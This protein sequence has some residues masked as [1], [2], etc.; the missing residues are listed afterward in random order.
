MGERKTERKKQQQQQLE[1]L[2]TRKKMDDCLG[3][4]VEQLVKSKWKY[5]SNG[6]W[7]GKILT[8]KSTHEVNLQQ[9][10]T[11][12]NPQKVGTWGSKGMALYFHVDCNNIV[13]ECLVAT[14]ISSELVEWIKV[15]TEECVSMSFVE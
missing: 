10:E 11:D 12:K 6:Q 8:F 7:N 15:N 9:S 2:I 14:S 5:K 3:G 1:K 4:F 13:E